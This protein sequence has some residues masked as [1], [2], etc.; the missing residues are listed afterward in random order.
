RTAPDGRKYKPLFAPLVVDLDNRLNVNVH[1]NA[2]GAA[3][4]HVSN[5]GW[6]PWGVNLGRGLNADGDEGEKLL[7]GTGP[8]RGPPGRYG[9]DARPSAAAPA[10]LGA[11]PHFYARADFDGCD[12]RAGFRPSGPALL[13]GYGA[14]PLSCFP[15]Y[16]GGYGDGSA[17]ECIDHPLRYN[18]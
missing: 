15:S 11:V 16:A 8:P 10:R 18:A 7:L 3:G 12:E 14:P 9:P 5:Q 1:G 2:R 6:G 4:A 13:P 17:D